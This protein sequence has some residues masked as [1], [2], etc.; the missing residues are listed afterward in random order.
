MNHPYR[1]GQ[2]AP[3]SAACVGAVAPASMGH[4]WALVLVGAFPVLC[5]AQFAFW[6]GS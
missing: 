2:L 4:G 3:V 5:L 6:P 1:L